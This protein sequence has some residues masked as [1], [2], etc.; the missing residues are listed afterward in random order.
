MDKPKIVVFTGAG[1]S[2]E[3]GISTFRDLNGLWNK[4]NV[5]DVASRD[6]WAKNRSLVNEFYNQRRRQLKECKP[7]AAHYAI[8]E[9][10]KHFEV[11]IA[12]Q[13]V[14]SLHEQAGSKNVLHLH[15]ELLKVRDE[16]TDE[17]YDWT[18]DLQDDSVSPNGNGL[19]PHIVFFQ[20]SVPNYPL[21]QEM[22]KGADI[23][24]VVGTSLEV[25]PAAGLLHGFKGITKIFNMDF[26]ELYSRDTQVIGPASQTV[27]KYVDE[28]IAQYS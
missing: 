4:H 3:S 14:D 21:A 5:H 20:E 27:T 22:R 23:L 28:L 13:N 24:I 11:Q 10:E 18:E 16:V 15:G 8:A 7:N 2:A 9:L 25:Y 1:V 6:G 26:N 12:T 19:R 17:T